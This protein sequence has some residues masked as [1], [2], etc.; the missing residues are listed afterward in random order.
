MLFLLLEISFCNN[1]PRFAQ[2]KAKLPK[3]SLA[4]ANPEINR[5]LL[6]D[7][8]RQGFAVPDIGS[9]SS[10]PRRFTQDFA[11]FVELLFAQFFGPA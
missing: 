4:L 10:A 1:R 7:E 2:P 6:P 9:E 5:V 11:D 3:K 8:D